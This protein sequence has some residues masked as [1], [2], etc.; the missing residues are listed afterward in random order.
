MPRKPN[1][2]FGRKERERLKAEKKAERAASKEEVR[3]RNTGQ[4]EF[5]DDLDNRVDTESSAN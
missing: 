4:S 5:A 3:N 1:Y 2:R